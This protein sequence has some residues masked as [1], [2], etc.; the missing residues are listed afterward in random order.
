ML[1]IFKNA[2]FIWCDGME[3]TVNAYADFFEKINKKTDSVYRMYIT[4][5][6]DYAVYINEQFCDGGQYADY[7]KK[8]KVYDELDLTKYLKD[9]E[10]DVLIVGYCQNE[11]S[12]TYRVGV[13]GVM[14]TITEDGQEIA[15]SKNAL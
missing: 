11:D 3:K 8:Y 5:D 10:N 9:G 12:S 13:A 7:S 2:K 4:A 14:Y 6:S 15:A 1:D